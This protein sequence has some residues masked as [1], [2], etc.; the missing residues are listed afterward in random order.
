MLNRFSH[1]WL[2]AT[3]WTIAHQA[4]L[5]MGFSSQEYWSGL[6][7]PPPGDLPDPVPSPGDLPDSGIKPTSALLGGFFTTE[8]SYS[9]YFPS[10]ATYKKKKNHR[11]FLGHNLIRLIKGKQRFLNCKLFHN[12]IQF[13]SFYSLL[14]FF[15]L[16]EEIFLFLVEYNAT[17]S[18][19]KANGI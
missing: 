17:K 10:K 14:F 4:P 9:R 16:K 1:V 3:P 5:S 13:P 19:C 8:P 11:L 12:R 18:R 15:F 7:C 6:P 2:F